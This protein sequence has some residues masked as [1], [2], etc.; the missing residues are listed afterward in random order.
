MIV[1]SLFSLCMLFVLLVWRL[2]GVWCLWGWCLCLGRGWMCFLVLL[3]L[4]L[5]L[6][7]RVSGF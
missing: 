5:C 3:C 7:L 4:I 1:L 2:V 6:V